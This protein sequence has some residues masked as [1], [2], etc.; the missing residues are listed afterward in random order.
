[1]NNLSIES[2][3]AN[4]TIS[5]PWVRYWARLMD[6]VIFSMAFGLAWGALSPQSMPGSDNV[7][8]ILCVILWVP[9]EA[10]ILNIYGTTF[11]RWL[12]RIKI[13]GD[14]NILPLS[15][16]L[17]R[18]FLVAF[19]GLGFGLPLVSIFT[20]ICA[21]SDL[22]KKGQTSWDKVCNLTVTHEKIGFVRLISAFFITIFIIAIMA[23]A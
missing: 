16:A 5:R 19:K 11:G 17:K 15:V 4:N 1:M 8:G 14:F 9:V 3:N 18:S 13:S 23:N 7:L 10:F 6:L 20:L 21:Y 2:E 22:T 12:L